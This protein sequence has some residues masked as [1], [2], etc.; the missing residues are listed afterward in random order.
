MARPGLPAPVGVAPT[1]QPE[2]LP[3]PNVREQLQQQSQAEIAGSIAKVNG[4]RVT[5]RQIRLIEEVTRGNLD[6]GPGKPGAGFL[7][8]LF[9]DEGIPDLSAEARGRLRRE[10]LVISGWTMLA[11]SPEVDF[12]QALA[13]GV[14]VARLHITQTAGELLDEQNRQQRII[15]RADVLEKLPGLPG[16]EELRRRAIA[17]GDLDTVD[18]LN[19]V[20][21]ELRDLEAGQADWKVVNVA[22]RS[23]AMDGEGNLRDPFSKEI[24][25]ERPPAE[26]GP[27]FSLS[28]GQVRFDAQG[29]P[30][31]SVEEPAG[32][33]GL[34]GAFR[35][36]IVLPDG[37]THT[38][39]FDRGGNPIRDLGVSERPEAAGGSPDPKVLQIAGELRREVDNIRGIL[40]DDPSTPEVEGAEKFGFTGALGR[41]ARLLPAE[42]EPSDLKQIR[43]ASQN[44]LSLIVRQRSGAQAT[45]A[46]V[47]RLES[48]AVPKAGDDP[49]TIR[50]KLERLERIIADFEQGGANAATDR[51]IQSPPSGFDPDEIRAAIRELRGGGS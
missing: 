1:P 20:I 42:I 40:G 24:V 33:G 13:L 22:G 43:A 34:E 14:L 3:G 11:S 5:D 12:W 37:S 48:F 18:T 15:E 44:I 17:E 4:G 29:R 51:I 8:F 31:A 38:V 19:D 25:I 16:F 45:E 41:L 6:S 35:E 39:L 27:G 49:S 21:K 50:T 23:F 26:P 28:P 30:I 46:E 47:K 36:D 2:Q 9:G 32:S 7:G 10:G